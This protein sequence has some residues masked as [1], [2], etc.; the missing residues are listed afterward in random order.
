MIYAFF[1][2]RWF[3]IRVVELTVQIFLYLGFQISNVGC[4]IL[5]NF[6]VNWCIRSV[7]GSSDLIFSSFSNVGVE[8][9]NLGF[10]WV[11]DSMR[12]DERDTE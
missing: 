12:C 8:I 11:S 6:Y 3:H 9:S 5:P 4:N 2:S 1:G 7:G 10:V